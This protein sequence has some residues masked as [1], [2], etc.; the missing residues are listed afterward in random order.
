MFSYAPPASKLVQRYKELEL[1]GGCDSIQLSRLHAAVYSAAPDNSTPCH[2]STVNVG[3]NGRVSIAEPPHAPHLAGGGVSRDPKD[4]AFKFDHAFD[5]ASSGRLELLVQCSEDALASWLRGFN[6]CVVLMGQDSNDA[7]SDNEDMSWK[8]RRASAK[9]LSPISTAYPDSLDKTYPAHGPEASLAHRILRD[10]FVKLQDLPEASPFS[11]GISVFQV[12]SDNRLEDVLEGCPPHTSCTLPGLTCIHVDSF[13]EAQAVLASV[14]Q[15]NISGTCDSDPPSGRSSATSATETSRTPSG[16]SSATSATQTSRTPSVRSLATAATGTLRTPSGRAQGHRFLRLLLRSGASQQES[17]LT[18]VDLKGAEPTKLG[19]GGQNSGSRKDA[20]GTREASQQL[21]SLYKMIRELSQRQAE[22]SGEAKPVALHGSCLCQILGPLLAGNTAAH[23]VAVVSTA[24]QH[25]Q[26]T[27]HLLKL[28]TEAQKINTCLTKT[29]LEDEKRS[30]MVPFHEFMESTP[31]GGGRGVTLDLVANRVTHGFSNT[32]STSEA[33]P[34][35]ANR[36]TPGLSMTSGANKAKPL[37][38][39][40][41]PRANSQSSAR[42]LAGLGNSEGETKPPAVI[43]PSAGDGDEREQEVEDPWSSSKGGPRT[44]PSVGPL[45]QLKNRLASLQARGLPHP[46]PQPQLQV[47]ANAQQQHPSQTQSQQQSQ[48][49]PQHQHQSGRLVKKLEL[50]QKRDGE[51]SGRQDRQ[52]AAPPSSLEPSNSTP[53]LGGHTTTA[54]LDPARASMKTGRSLS[55]GS[56]SQALS[57][58]PRSKPRQLGRSVSWANLPAIDSPVR[59]SSGSPSCPSAP[60]P[61]CASSKANPGCAAHGGKAMK[62]YAA[63]HR[64][65]A[66]LTGGTDVALEGGRYADTEPTGTNENEAKQLEQGH[67]SQLHRGQGAHSRQAYDAVATTRLEA[68]PSHNH[69]IIYPSHGPQLSNSGGAA[70]QKLLRSKS[71]P[72]RQRPTSLPLQSLQHSDRSDGPAYMQVSSPNAGTLFSGNIYGGRGLVNPRRDGS[73]HRDLGFVNP[74]R[75]VSPHRILGFVSPRRPA[76]PSRNHYPAGTL[77]AGTGGETLG[78]HQS[79]DGDA[80]YCTA[81][82]PQAMYPPPP[83]DAIGT[84]SPSVPLKAAHL[85]AARV[86]RLLASSN[87]SRRTKKPANS[88]SEEERHDRQIR[89]YFKARRQSRSTSRSQISRGRASSSLENHLHILSPSRTSVTRSLYKAAK[90]PSALCSKIGHA[91]STSPGTPERMYRGTED[92]S[93]QQSPRSPARARA[94]SPTTYSTANQ[95]RSPHSPCASSVEYRLPWSPSSKA[96]H[97]TSEMGASGRHAFPGTPPS[98]A[99]KSP[100]HQ[101]YRTATVPQA[102][103]PPPPALHHISSLSHPVS[104]V[105]HSSSARDGLPRRSASPTH[106]AQFSSHSRRSAS[107]AHGAHFS[108]HTRRSAS[109]SHGAQFSNYPR[110]TTSPAANVPG[111]RSTSPM[112]EV[113]S[114]LPSPR[115]GPAGSRPSSPTATKGGGFGHNERGYTG[116]RPSSPTATIGGGFGRNE[117]GYTGSRPSSPTAMIGG[118]F[119]RNERGY[120]GSRP[121]SPT[122]WRGGGVGDTHTGSPGSVHFRISLLA[123]AGMG[124]T[125]RAR[126]SSEEEEEEGKEAAQALRRVLHSS[127]RSNP[128]HL[129]SSTLKLR[130]S[131]RRSTSVSPPLGSPSMSRA[132]ANNSHA[133]LNVIGRERR[134]YEALQLQVQQCEIDI[135]EQRTTAQR[136]LN[137]VGREWPKYGALELQVQQW[138]LGIV[139]QRTTAQI[140][141]QSLEQQL[142][143]LEAANKSSQAGAGLNE[144]FERYETDLERC[145]R[146]N[147]KLASLLTTQAKEIAEHELANLPEDLAL[148]SCKGERRRFHILQLAADKHEQRG[149][150]LYQELNEQKRQNRMLSLRELESSARALEEQAIGAGLAAAEARGE[151]QRLELLVESLRTENDILCQQNEQLLLKRTAFTHTARGARGNGREEMSHVINS[152][153]SGD[154][155]VLLSG[156]ALSAPKGARSPS[157]PRRRAEGVSQAADR[158]ANDLESCWGWDEESGGHGAAIADVTLGTGPDVKSKDAFGYTGKKRSEVSGVTRCSDIHLPLDQLIHELQAIKRGDMDD[159]V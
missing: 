134:K 144:L 33:K 63:L 38:Q 62:S 90:R 39:Q 24:P 3:G 135:V 129:P 107:P 94:R 92:D 43:P 48:S 42:T 104:P 35:M 46:H 106:G 66:P 153:S 87:P 64:A 82:V 11:L 105:F 36:I 51:K 95:R 77:I 158:L 5:E 128:L 123:P 124:R 146:E 88:D 114:F 115:M 8:V 110:G 12:G 159:S 126:S 15:N 68:K 113:H 75:D 133:L 157:V 13:L 69:A 116:S 86:H 152:L 117:R 10:A 19:G 136:V 4:H 22:T 6:S 151:R 103:C 150:A 121:S 21:S 18:V 34:A 58:S 27:M 99:P 147:Q 109:P 7:Y 120:T 118:G 52:G 20:V 9:V 32:N 122:A 96:A 139:E 67:L 41:P 89:L 125:S 76:S 23:L 45:S 142:S 101:K 119:G 111:R 79:D 84:A 98:P 130:S 148:S 30:A 73:L 16:R 29:I 155:G 59:Q 100:P 85:A 140:R 154:Y 70:A 102:L 78:R 31:D 49:Q 112:H 80:Q 14:L 132:P 71:A 83:S 44:T 97:I 65:S 55:R 141:E 1:L 156:G 61:A 57:E 50:H 40:V 60:T 137:V 72:A 127:N 53:A 143:H 93:P 74:Q 47:Q 26:T 17:V 54:A 138:D 56:T 131:S 149:N 108:S 91:G 25:Y 2:Q 37:R 145:Q 28:L 81:T